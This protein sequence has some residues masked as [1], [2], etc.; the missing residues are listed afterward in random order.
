MK[1][2]ILFLDWYKTLSFDLF[3]QKIKTQH[4]LQFQIIESS[5]FNNGEMMKKWMTGQCT[6]EEICED[7][8]SRSTL[9]SQELFSELQ[10]CCS[11]MNVHPDIIKIITQLRDHHHIIITTDNMDCFSRFT[12][13]EIGIQSWTDDILNS[14]DLRR[15]K[16]DENGKTFRD[17]TEKFQIPF[18]QTIC[19]DDSTS[20]CN[21]IR[22]L[23]GVALQTTGEIET[24]KLLKS[25]R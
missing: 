9:L 6:S 13:P 19:I 10:L 14:S 7:I 11:S 5:I 20:T 21:L 18:H 25:L 2:K 8:S 16:N 23:G 22:S 3:W 1:E 24:L 17:M 15:L 4:P 12:V